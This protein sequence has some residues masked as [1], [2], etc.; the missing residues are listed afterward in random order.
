MELDLLPLLRHVAVVVKVIEACRRR[1]F[2]FAFF[3]FRQCPTCHP[4]R[5]LASS[6]VQSPLRA[7][8]E[9]THIN[10]HFSSQATYI[11][12]EKKIRLF[13][14][15]AHLRMKYEMGVDRVHILSVLKSRLQIGE[16]GWEI[17]GIVQ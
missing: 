1:H 10:Y 8:R 5:P 14:H 4:L 6:S 11:N 3:L 16:K 13:H 2:L 15:K 17:W 9:S 7:N 12:I